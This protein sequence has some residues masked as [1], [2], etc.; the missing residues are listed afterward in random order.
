MVLTAPPRYGAY[1]TLALDA[2]VFLS[3]AVKSIDQERAI[4]VRF[5]SQV[6]NHHRLAAFSTVRLH[7]IQAM[8]NLRQVLEAGACAAFAIANP[9][10]SHFANATPEGTFE[11]SPTLNAKRHEWLDRYFPQASS[12]IK[13]MKG[14]INKSMAHANIVYTQNTFRVADSGDEFSTPFFDIENEC[15]V[16][17]DLLTAS[18]I[19]N[20]LIDLFYQVNKDVKAIV[21]QD[22]FDTRFAALIEREKA[23]KS[24]MRSSDLFKETE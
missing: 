24:E 10:P 20:L 18:G 17:V 6:K 21:W 4:F 1:Y 22:D 14:Q 19:A 23:L 5:L 12:Y 16:I 11:T 2:S 3:V 8:M 15:F 13:A 9:D 7:R